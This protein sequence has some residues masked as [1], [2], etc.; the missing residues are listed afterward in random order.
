MGT[1]RRMPG[2]IMLLVTPLVIYTMYPPELRRWIIK[3]SLKRALPNWD[4]ENPRKNAARCLCA[5]ATGLD[6]SKSLGVDEST[7]AIVVM[8]TMR[9]WV[10]LPGKTW[11][12]IKAAGIPNLVRRYYRIKLLIIES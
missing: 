6:F 1:G 8:A 4:R 12:K 11:L 2:I 3:P 7:V 5:G 10:S 9:C